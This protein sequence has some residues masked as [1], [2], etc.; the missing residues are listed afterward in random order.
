MGVLGP[1]FNGLANV[2]GYQFRSDATGSSPPV[3]GKCDGPAAIQIVQIQ[4]ERPQ[5]RLNHH[6]HAMRQMYTRQ[7]FR[8]MFLSCHFVSLLYC[9]VNIVMTGYLQVSFR[10]QR[11]P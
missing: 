2:Y 7:V 4:P 1:L 10:L 8:R 9:S 5:Y 11:A 6:F 3:D